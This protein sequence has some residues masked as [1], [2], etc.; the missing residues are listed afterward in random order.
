MDKQKVTL[1]LLLDLSAAFDTVSHA[2]LIQRLRDR[3]G[4]RHEALDWFI[5]YLS[6]RKQCVGING[7]NSESIKLMFGV[8]QGSVLGPILF[9]IYTLPLA[10]I[11]RNYGVEFHFYADDT[12]IYMSFVPT[13]VEA[14]L[15]TDLL[16]DCVKEIKKWMTQ[17]MLQLNSDKT[18]I[19]LFGT[20]QQLSKVDDFTFNSS[21]DTIELKPAWAH[22][23][24]EV[25]K[26][27]F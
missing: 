27:S 16:S 13:V 8:P 11:L 4:I 23:H 12:Q 6:G 5:S 25:C 15:T 7:T 24:T 1:L 10:E 21:G 22:K 2:I 20:P 17:N 26:L 19:I 9:L 18:E 14:E 3:V